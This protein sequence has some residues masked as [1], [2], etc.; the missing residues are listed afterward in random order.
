MRWFKHLTDSY[1]NIKHREIV[2]DFGLEGYGLYW[3]CL[4][5]IGQQG[6]N[7]RLNSTKSWKKA[8]KSASGLSE[9]KMEKILNRFGELNLVC[10]KSLAKGDLYVPKMKER[11]DE[12]TTRN[13]REAPELL[14]IEY[15]R[16][17]EIRR[18]YIKL[19]GLDIKN[20][21]PD[22]YARTAKAIKTLVTKAR[23]KD[24]LVIEGLRWIA[25][26]TYEWTLE[27]LSR[28]WI[29]FMKYKQTPEIERKWIKNE[30]RRA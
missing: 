30:P 18:E 27:T 22:D 5:L 6:H 4:E 25:S 20:F 21:F 9:E 2:N 10:P 29:E 23:G 19:K 24:E 15:N 8:L 26:Q 14:R 11:A 13:S 17:E 28:K 1:I 3:I 7:F 16:I 12:W